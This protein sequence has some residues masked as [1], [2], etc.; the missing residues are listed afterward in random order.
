VVLIRTQNAFREARRDEN[1]LI[2]GLAS[3]DEDESQPREN[4]SLSI[5]ITQNIWVASEA[6]PVSRYREI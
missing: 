2:R 5:E 3:Y 6:R 1:P 4:D